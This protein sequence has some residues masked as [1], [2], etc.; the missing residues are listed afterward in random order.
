MKVA[1]SMIVFNSDEILEAA[2][3][4]AY[5]FAS[6]IVITEGPVQ[7]YVDRGFTTSTDNTVEIIKSFPDPAKKIT[8]IQGQWPEKTEMM[9]AQTEYVHPDT[10]HAWMVDADEVYKAADVARVLEMLPGYDSVGFRSMSFYGDFKTILTGFEQ[11]AEY[12]RIQRWAES[13]WHQHRKPTILNPESGRPWREHRH[14]SFKR[15]AAE[16][17]YLYHY[18]YVF[19]SQFQRKV[20][21]MS[22]HLGKGKIIDDYYNQVYLR[23]IRGDEAARQ[24]IEDRY[25]GVH[26]FLPRYR[27][28]CRTAR[29][30]GKHPE[31]IKKRL[32]ALNTRLRNDL[33]A[34]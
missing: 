17:I 28:T 26:E 19:P 6:Q 18:T 25:D 21:Y 2:L 4:S 3:E 7:Y 29:F 5:Q 20:G 10:D 22:E 31:A 24:R 30:T 15:L 33:L 8:L 16:G 23:W 12:Q 32:S 13:G 1:V 14:L 34:V 9:Q 11:Q 27:G